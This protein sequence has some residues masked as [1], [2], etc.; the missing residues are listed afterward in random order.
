MAT[1]RLGE[2]RRKLTAATA[3]IALQSAL[4][5]QALSKCGEVTKTDGNLQVLPLKDENTSELYDPYVQR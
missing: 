1:Q 3:L 4:R 2:E 5:T